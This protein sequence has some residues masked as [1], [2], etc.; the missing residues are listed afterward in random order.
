MS[1]E[2]QKHFAHSDILIGR[3]LLDFGQNK[4]DANDS[5]SMPPPDSVAT[6]QVPT[7]VT[8]VANGYSDCLTPADDARLLNIKTFFVMMNN[9]LALDI[10]RNC[11]VHFVTEIQTTYLVGSYLFIILL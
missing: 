10:A 7:R 3:I 9:N 11:R 4:M 1:D 5:L 6:S 8:F 2:A